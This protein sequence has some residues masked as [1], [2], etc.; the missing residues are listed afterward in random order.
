[1]DEALIQIIT[2]EVLKALAAR[3]ISVRKSTGSCASSCS[4]PEGSVNKCG[5]ISPQGG[6]AS[7]KERLITEAVA[8]SLCKGGICEVCIADNTLVTPSAW[9]VFK[10]N[11]VKVSRN[12]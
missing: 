12:G 3:G 6:R 7:C 11:K 1:M 4:K 9:D 8:A 2:E 5:N 10:E